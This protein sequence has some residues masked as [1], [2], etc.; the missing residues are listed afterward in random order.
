MRCARV[1]S[2]AQP[3]TCMHM[4]I[5]T[6]SHMHMRTL[7]AHA[8]AR[9]RTSF[10][11]SVVMAHFFSSAFFSSSGLPSRLTDRC[12]ILW[13]ASWE[14]VRKALMML[15][16]HGGAARAAAGVW[17]SARPPMQRTHACVHACAHCLRLRPQLPLR[18]HE[19]GARMRR[20][21]CGCPPTRGC[22]PSSTNAFASFRNSPARM[23]TDVVPSPT[24]REE[25]GQFAA[26]GNSSSLR[27]PGLLPRC[28]ATHLSILRQRHVHQAL[29][30]R[31]HD[32]QQLHDRGPVV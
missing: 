18:R 1:H 17:L 30:C 9:T 15:W 2:H 20:M 7:N 5:H 29:G 25:A 23:T 13:M 16:G 10:E 11:F 19:H 4:P 12:L 27:A 22:A 14:A 28:P 32:V 26:G 8:H 6:Q 3:H 31:V 24:C 21:Q